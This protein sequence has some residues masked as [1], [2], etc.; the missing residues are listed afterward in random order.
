M[1]STHRRA[2]I[3]AVFAVV[4][5]GASFVATKIA[6]RYALPVVI[7]WIRF[8]IGVILLGI[9]V[10]ATKKAALPEKKDGPY[11]AVLGFLGITL[12][13]WLQSTGLVT[14]AATTTGWIVASMPIFI[15]LLGWVFLKEK[16]TVF[17]TIGML[18]SAFGV[19]VVVT[20]G[21]LSQIF[22]G[23]SFSPGDLLILI[24]AP[25]WALFTVLSRRGLKRYPA[26]LMM[27]YVM[28]FGCLFN[29]LWFIGE[30]G[31]KLIGSMPWNGWISILFLGIFCSGLAYIFWYDALQTLSAAKTGAY[32]YIEPVITL[33][34]AAVLLHEFITWISLLGGG[35]ILVGVWMVNHKVEGSENRE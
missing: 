19:L 24:S 35:L 33:L 31:V 13:Q 26:I 11:F 27:F 4:V 10:V 6:L 20:R 30:G 7:V 16:F 12:H 5:W 32:L 8:S 18:L 34:I 14:A 3:E 9:T 15:A 29:A 2:V 17:Q 21:N 1:T 28:A 25:N 23:V 22:S